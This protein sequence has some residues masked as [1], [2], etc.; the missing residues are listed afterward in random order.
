MFLA[1]LHCDILWQFIRMTT[2]LLG[3]AIYARGNGNDLI[4]GF[5]PQEV[6]LHERH[7]KGCS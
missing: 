7:E 2:E 6:G 3:G 1:D 5:W 4:G